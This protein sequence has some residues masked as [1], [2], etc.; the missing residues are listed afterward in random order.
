MVSKI[1]TPAEI[2][3]LVFSLGSYLKFKRSNFLITVIIWVNQIEYD[4]HIN[5]F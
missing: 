1:I 3:K 2:M 4:F 5:V